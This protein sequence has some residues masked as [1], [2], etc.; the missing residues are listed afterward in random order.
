MSSGDSM[1]KNTLWTDIIGQKGAVDK[2]LG[3]LDSGEAVHAWLFTGPRGVGK[4]TT[5][6]IMAAA[7]NCED[8]GCG[9][10]L[11]C[12][13][14]LREIHPDIFLV[15]PEGN[16]ILIEQ[17]RRLLQS[18]SLKNYEGKTKVI[19][20]D[21][22]DKLTTEAA[23][24]L[25]KTL[26]EP[27]QNLVFILISSNIDALLPTIISRCRLVQFRPLPVSEMISFLVERYNL[28]Y[29]EAALATRL[30][31]SILGNAISFAISPV[32]KE[33]RKKVLRIV[34]DIDRFDLAGLTF[35]A[36]ELLG[37]VKRPLNELKEK[38]KK[39]IS[40]L[41]SQFN[42][43]NIPPQIKK[44][45]EQRQKRELSYEE[46]QGFEEILGIMVSWF[47]DIILLKE[48]G[49][50]DLLLNKDYIL[51]V[52]ETVELLTSQDIYRCLQIIEETKQY[53]RFNVN[54]QLAFE[55]MLFKIHDVIKVQNSH[56][57]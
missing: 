43:G 49:R 1:S 50:E 40:E 15:E 13:K 25:L 56:F 22:A 42:L 9:T 48:T 33:R 6:K 7:L 38:H 52:K 14:V 54:M 55:T 5:A 28:S 37:E 44:R 8:N 20:I 47:R 12:S 26:E 53:L 35:V 23:N 3:S 51:A 11:S 32:K 41:K 27:P 39:E 24:T 2:I 16:F 17:I 30:S 45:I 4:W 18:I 31:G 10:C 19:I 29:E 21:E 57:I 36:E 46:H 34:Q